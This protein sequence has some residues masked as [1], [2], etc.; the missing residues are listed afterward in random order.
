[1][2]EWKRVKLGEVCE[3]QRGYDLPHAKMLPGKYPVIGSSGIIGWHNDYTTEAPSVSIGRSGSVG[4]PYLYRGKSWSHNTALYIKDFKSNDPIFV[5]YFLFAVRPWEYGGGSAVPTLNRNDLHGL[6]VSLPPLPT[7]R[8]IAAVLGALDDKIENNRKI[9]ANLEAQAQALFKS[10]F[11]DFEP[12]GGKMPSGWKMGKLGEIAECNKES[13]TTKDE[14]DFVNYLDTGSITRNQIQDIQLM[15]MSVAPSRARRKVHELS[16][17]YS[18]VRPNQYHYGIVHNVKENMLVST[19]FAV[20]DANNKIASYRLFLELT[21]DSVTK[22]FQTLAEQSVC[23][24]PAINPSDILAHQIVI[25]TLTVEQNFY[26][27]VS[28]MFEKIELANQESRARAATRDALLSKLMSGE[29]DVGKV[30]V[31]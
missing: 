6:E 20:I 16:I 3:F 22:H 19:G 27:T 2:A 28:P 25:P 13:Y 8:K 11:V 29:V 23:T 9:C 18:T 4:R 21:Q 1:M 5:Y 14:W 10:W 31:A 30:E 7:Q 26:S 15:P 12:F 17:V 24:Y